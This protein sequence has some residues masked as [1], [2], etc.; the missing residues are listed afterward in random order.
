MLQEALKSLPRM[1]EMQSNPGGAVL[2]GKRER[3]NTLASGHVFAMATRP[4]NSRRRNHRH[5]RLATMIPLCSSD[6]IVSATASK[7]YI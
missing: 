6:A 5:G 4:I 7:V 2:R 3:H 1:E